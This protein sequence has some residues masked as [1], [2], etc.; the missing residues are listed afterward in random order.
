MANLTDPSSTAASAPYSQDLAFS[1]YRRDGHPIQTLEARAAQNSSSEELARDTF[2]PTYQGQWQCVT[3]VIESSVADIPVGQ[4]ILS[5]LEFIK[6]PDGRLTANWRQPG[7]TE[8]QA[9]I[10][11]YKNNQARLDRTNYFTADAQGHS[12]LARSRDKFKPLNSEQM[13]A[14]SYVDQ[15]LD[16]QY[17]GRY[18]TRSIL[19]RIP[20]D[21]A[22]I[23]P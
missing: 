15:Y 8:S 7:W 23:M 6:Q 4:K 22:C 18:R 9:S 17:I 5:Q 19:I 3:E 1:A 16:G 2:P 12:W 13:L 10:I 21:I 11:S 20:S 14:K